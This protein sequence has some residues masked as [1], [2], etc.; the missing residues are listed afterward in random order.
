MPPKKGHET[1][2]MTV[3]IGWSIGSPAGLSQEASIAV[4]QMHSLG[5]TTSKILTLAG[6]LSLS[7]YGRAV[8]FLRVIGLMAWYMLVY[9][10]MEKSNVV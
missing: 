9:G 8:E 3:H 10:S 1:L 5:P 4:S 2:S 7:T 6:G